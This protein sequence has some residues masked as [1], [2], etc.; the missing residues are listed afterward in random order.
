MPN[1]KRQL[2]ITINDSNKFARTERHKRY[3]RRSNARAIAAQRL[4]A[5]D[6]LFSRIGNV[7]IVSAAPQDRLARSI[8]RHLTRRQEEDFD[9]GLRDSVTYIPR[10]LNNLSEVLNRYM[11]RVMDGE[12]FLI[13]FD[14]TW[15]ALHM[16]T[17][18][19]LINVAIPAQYTIVEE[20]ML[21][22]SDIELVESTVRGGKVTISRAPDRPGELGAYNF[23][24]GEF[25]PYVHDYEC[26]YLTELLARLGCWK[27]VDVKNYNENCLWLA[28]K[29]AGVDANILESM[30]VS[31][32][33]RKIA[34]KEI[35]SIAE[36]H[37][38][39]VIIHTKGDKNL[40]KCGPV[41]GYEVN[42]FLVNDH[43]IHNF[44][45]EVTAHA[46]R[47]YDTLK[48]KEEWWRIESNGKR[49][50]GR[51]VNT[52]D[53]L[54]IVMEGTHLTKI[55]AVT[56][57]IFRT[58][59]H[60]RM[61][62]DNFETLEYPK[63]AVKPA[64][65]ERGEG[66]DEYLENKDKLEKLVIKLE[67]KVDV[68]S[69]LTRKFEMLGM[70]LKE[71]IN[72]LQKHAKPTVQVVYDFEAC[73]FNEHTPFVVCWKED[74]SNVNE[75]RGFDCAKQFLDALA[76]KYGAVL[77][78]DSYKRD[79]PKAR[80]LA[81]N[82][83]YDMSFLFEHVSQLKLLN[84]G[85]NIVCGSARYTCLEGEAVTGT[86]KDLLLW[87]RDH[88]KN[89]F[90]QRNGYDPFG[91]VLGIQIWAKA[92][93]KVRKHMPH[94]QSAEDCIFISDPVVLDV[95]RCAP[96]STFKESKPFYLRKVIDLEFRDTYKMISEPLSKFGKMFKL[97]QE[98][99]V[100]PY[101]LYTKEFVERG[102]FATWGEIL[103]VP[104]FEEHAQLK[105]NLET[106]GCARSDEKGVVWYDMMEYAVTYCRADVDILHQGWDKFREMA[107]DNFDMDINAY[108]TISSLSKAYLEER[109][110]YDGVYDMSGVPLQFHRNA[111]VGGRVMCANNRRSFVEEDMDDTDANSLYPS[112]MVRLGGFLK[113]PP[114]VIHP[115]VDLNSVDGYCIKIRVTKMGRKLR[116]PNCRL[117]TE[118]G[119]CDWT[120][121][122][123]G[124]EITVDKW[125]LEDLVKHQGDEFE[126]L[127]GYYYDEGR[128]YKLKEVIQEMYDLRL[129]YKREGNPLQQVY[130]L[131]LN[132]AYGICGLKPIETDVR[133]VEHDKRDSFIALNFNRIRDFTRMSNGVYRFEMYKQIE[134]H[135][136]RQHCAMEV[137]SMSKAI[138]NEVQVLAEDLGIDIAYQDTDSLHVPAKDS[139]RL[140]DAFRKEYG[141]ELIGKGLGQFS[142][143]FEFADAWHFRDGTYRKV[144]SSIKEDHKGVRAVHFPI[145][146]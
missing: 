17:F 130:K 133:Y 4:E 56:K 16:D 74:C 76:R 104:D 36:K 43:Y 23:N 92:V 52:K 83:T 3:A 111:S 90:A 24:A 26:K 134:T 61:K 8:R 29:D 114:K 78:D 84:R 117:K 141:K 121:D 55:S 85:T 10:N 45:T 87:M 144:G 71:Q 82:Q 103:R 101:K 9:A 7:S 119:G 128:N 123:V 28:F 80:M 102:C 63:C 137:L 79:I 42:L 21:T 99:E 145:D 18:E 94:L 118:E 35:K 60:D 5:G 136:N 54:Q 122:L 106:W 107:L 129:K 50:K 31:F 98:K 34:R 110:V 19:R 14:G 72:L 44:K 135:F 48:D 143:D 1:L 91:N 115:G 93:Q 142:S 13:D 22:K 125:T 53:L 127:Q 11:G 12:R 33:Q 51:G 132:S 58:Q 146:L 64:I 32:R 70:G 62:M 140:A 139:A 68:P 57:G 105:R 138:M 77:N 67:R 49:D 89:L 6:R 75:A 131:M 39:Y 100:M 95:V 59:F 66:V 116:F 108:V 47:N 40:V 27:S 20:V 109:G 15:Y 124:K 65:P 88:G 69:R 37:N 25:F 97:P 30:K 126:V 86:N 41:E 2:E 73:P 81:H 96:W 113:G 38:L 112:A 46:L 120:N